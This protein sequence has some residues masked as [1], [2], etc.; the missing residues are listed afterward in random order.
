MS[1]EVWFRNP[2][3]YI[4]ELVE[5][6]EYRIAWDRGLLVKKNIDPIKHAELYFGKAY[7]YRLLLVGEQGTAELRSGST[8][9]KPA[10][11]YPTWEYGDDAN[12]LEEL[13]AHPI[14]EDPAI[15]ND[16]TI[17]SS[18]RPVFGQE[19]RVVVSNIP[20]ATSGPGRGFLKYL[21][22]LQEEYPKAILHVH[23]LYGFKV[24]FGL[25]FRAADME[26]RT[27]A[28]K[29]KVYLPSGAEVKYE[30]AA[31]NPKWV[32]AVGFL[33]ADLAVPRNR[34]MFN[35]KSAIWAGQYYNELFNFRTNK[36]SA[37]VD[38]QTPDSQYQPVVRPSP[39]TKGT[40]AKQGDKFQCNTCSLAPSCNYFREGAVCS[41]P[42]SEPVELARMFQSRDSGM[43]IDGLGTLLA[44]N[45]RRLE[46]GLR[47]EEALGDRNPEVT[48]QM[49]QVFDQGIKLAKL[50]DPSLRGG[51]SVQVNVGGGGVASRVAQANPQQ[52]VAAVFRE[53]R[54]QGVPEEEIT[55]DMV[56]HVLENM[57]NARALPEAIHGEVLSRKD[58]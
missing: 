41:V 2:D 4:R 12:I 56:T 5:C 11:V 31:A 42:G 6:G 27:N 20:N 19:H 17:D 39:F 26:P 50:I 13:L 18:E 46:S 28:Q 7:P 23:G 35:I 53:L 14:G 24:A 51:P 48:R 15:C 9:S 33:P 40:V 37:P 34:C 1:T 32:T 36:T 8:I 45:T 22:E 29:G 44:A 55:A 25:G 21:K 3:N 49:S 30:Q 47:E 57:S 58:N 54:A 52:M 10:A 38:A 43:I 16:V